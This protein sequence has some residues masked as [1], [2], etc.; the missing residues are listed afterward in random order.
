MC[1]CNHGECENVFGM[2]DTDHDGFI[3]FEEMSNMISQRRTLE[4]PNVLKLIF[5]AVDEDKN[6]KIDRNEFFK[7]SGEM[8]VLDKDD[9]LAGHKVLFKLIDKNGDGKLS[10]N[11][12][13][14]FF[15]AN[16]KT[17]KFDYVKFIEAADKNGDGE[18]SLDEFL[19]YC[20]K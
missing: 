18:I 6:G 13:K 10:H 19:A 11:E 14:S 1:E 4:D 20:C 12:I 15:E 3:T 8:S 5:N 17:E 2:M 16:G 9:K 7:F